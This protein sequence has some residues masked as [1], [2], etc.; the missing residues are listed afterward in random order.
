MNNE[1]CGE[2]YY[3]VKEP[4]FISRLISSSLNEKYDYVGEFDASTY[5]GDSFYDIFDKEEEIITEVSIVWVNTYRTVWEG[6][7]IKI[8]FIG[9]P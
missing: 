2:D 1:I 8:L 7:V 6:R 4:E 5:S 9:L 3:L